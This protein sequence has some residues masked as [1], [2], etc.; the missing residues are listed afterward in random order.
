MCFFS[1]HSLLSTLYHRTDDKIFK[2]VKCIR[3]WEY[4]ALDLVALL[5]LFCS[6]SISFISSFHLYLMRRQWKRKRKKK[7]N[8]RKYKLLTY[9]HVEFIRIV[10]LFDIA[11][12]NEIRATESTSPK[13]NGQ[14]ENRQRMIS[15]DLRKSELKLH[16][17]RT[18]NGRSIPSSFVLFF[19][20]LS[21]CR[22]L[23]AF[24]SAGFFLRSSLF[25]FR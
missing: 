6:M 15:T 25:G 17:Y 2:C 3:R 10:G 12:C 16:K 13:I 22:L 4:F 19:T 5:F 14:G 11:I 18:Y 23:F 1:S 24:H 20:L 8:T 9:Q 21:F 7:K